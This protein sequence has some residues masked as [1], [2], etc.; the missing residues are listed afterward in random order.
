MASDALVE[1]CLELLAPL[2]SVTARRMFGGHGLR[3][4]G[5]FFGLIVFDRLYLK[6]TP[7]RHA[8]G[9]RGRGWTA[10][11]LRRQGQAGDD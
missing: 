7:C 11:S 6:S 4:D 10:L 3:V 9:L 5:L 2:G 8:A 1:H